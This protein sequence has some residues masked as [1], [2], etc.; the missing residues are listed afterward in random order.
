MCL[1]T[2]LIARSE[3]NRNFGNFLGVAELGGRKGN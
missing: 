1:R 2:I 3:V